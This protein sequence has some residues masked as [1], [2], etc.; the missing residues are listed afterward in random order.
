MHVPRYIHAHTMHRCMHMCT[1]AR[2][3]ARTRA[4]THHHHHHHHN[5]K[6]NF[7]HKQVWI[8]FML[9]LNICFCLTISNKLLRKSMWKH[10]T[11]MCCYN[12]KGGRKPARITGTVQTTYRT[13]IQSH[14]SVSLAFLVL[15]AKHRSLNVA[16]TR[17][18]VL[19][20]CAQHSV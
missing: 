2:T 17:T 14:S 13:K 15:L 11:D 18:W 20:F 10:K 8:P 16:K 3:H 9:F 12:L 6:H 5:Q 19:P 4:H 7:I 1:H